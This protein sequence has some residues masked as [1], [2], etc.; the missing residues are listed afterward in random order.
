M[1]AQVVHL[2]WLSKFFISSLHADDIV[3]THTMYRCAHT[4]VQCQLHSPENKL[5]FFEADNSHPHVSLWPRANSHFQC[6][7]TYWDL[8]NWSE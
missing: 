4:D 1:F 7:Q 5:H 6:A 2:L 3:T 8:Y